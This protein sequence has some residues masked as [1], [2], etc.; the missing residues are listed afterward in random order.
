VPWGGVAAYLVVLAV[1]IGCWGLAR[2][3][4]LPVALVALAV[5][6]GLGRP[7]AGL[8]N[9]P[10]LQTAL[11]GVMFHV[12]V[13][14][15]VL[16]FRLGQGLLR[17]PL[18]E[19]FRRSLPPLLL[20]TVW[21]AAGTVLL[22]VLLP[23]AA[24][25]RPFYRFTLP[26]AFV[27]AVFAPLSLRDV[28]GRAPADAG[29]LFFVAAA[30]VGTAYS[31]TPTLLWSQAGPGSI[32]RQPLLVLVESG[33]LG[34][35]AALLWVAATRRA[36]LPRF[37]VTIVLAIAAMEVAFSQ[38][39]W[40]PFTAL[41]FGAALGKMGV[42]EW[43]LP[44]SRA[45]FSEAP[46]VLIVAAAFAPDLW[47][48]SMAGPS[49]LHLA[50]LAAL[51]LLVRAKAPGGRALVTGPGLLFLGLALTVRLD[52]AMGPI[53]RY[54]VDFAL[55]AWA[56]LRLLM[57]ILEQPR[58]APAPATRPAGSPPTSSP[59]T[60]PSGSPPRTRGSDPA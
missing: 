41:G 16:G 47:Q 32:W 31:F 29:S 51:L 15:G 37:P 40:P 54:A 18:P 50:A 52:R 25:D 48:D 58:K 42:A 56:G 53:T 57:W 9:L 49:L 38:K 7:G 12:A 19:I 3:G 21:L 43:R 22:P 28:R 23:E 45:I 30:L 5:G 11:P 26:L 36:R 24:G 2:L 8:V 33:A 55:P 34:F 17:L 6:L 59:R 39:L 35:I 10:T 4:A 20:A 46:F 60:S 14:L 13:V 27:T 1:A 44:G